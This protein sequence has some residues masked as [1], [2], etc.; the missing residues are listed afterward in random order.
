MGVGSVYEPAYN[1][2]EGIDPVDAKIPDITGDGL[3]FNSSFEGISYVSVERR[4]Y[5]IFY[6]VKDS[7]HNV[8]DLAV[9]IVHIY[10]SQQFP[11]YAFASIVNGVELSTMTP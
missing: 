1:I 6:I 2:T 5:K 4:T 8:S 11:G 7:W 9:R 10:K 3:D